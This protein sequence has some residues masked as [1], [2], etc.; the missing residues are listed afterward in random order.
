MAKVCNNLIT[1]G[2]SGSLGDQFVFRLGKG[3]QT[4]VATN[5]AIGLDYSCSSTG[6][7]PNTTYWYRVNAQNASGPSAWSNTA[8]ATTLAITGPT[9][10]QIGSIIVTTINAGQGNKRGQATVVMVN[11]LGGL[12]AGAT[13]RHIQ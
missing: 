9:S 5:P 11:P 8:S 4:I 1:Q 6:L 10:V 2:L 3:G 13:Y 7:S 12:E